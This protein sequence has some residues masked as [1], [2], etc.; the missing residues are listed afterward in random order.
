MSAVRA[1]E[2]RRTGG[3]VRALWAGNPLAVVQRGLIDARSSSWAIVLSPTSATAPG[4]MITTTPAMP[5]AM[6]SS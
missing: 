4:A 5:T 2:R 1:P 3:G 6:P